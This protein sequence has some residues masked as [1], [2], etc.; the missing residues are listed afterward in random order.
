MASIYLSFTISNVSLRLELILFLV[1]LFLVIL[2]Q[3]VIFLIFSIFIYFLILFSYNLFD[4]LVIL[5]FQL[6]LWLFQVFI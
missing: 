1:N 6:K 5:A 2:L 4:V 3:Y